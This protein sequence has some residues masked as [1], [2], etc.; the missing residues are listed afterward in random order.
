[1]KQISCSALQ[2]VHKTTEY[3]GLDQTLNTTPRAGIKTSVKNA[4]NVLSQHYSSSSDSNGAQQLVC[5][6]N[7][8]C[9]PRWRI[10]SHT[11][12]Y[13]EPISLPIQR[14]TKTADAKGTFTCIHLSL[15][16]FKKILNHPCIFSSI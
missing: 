6:R 2:M 11:V 12:L 9:I 8:L 16:H 15:L 4:K 5:R 7:Q 3:K 1:M 14:G 13:I 10:R